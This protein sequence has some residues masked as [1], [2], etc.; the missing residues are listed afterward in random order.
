MKCYVVYSTFPDRSVARRIARELVE[1]QLVACVNLI[2][3]VES[4]YSWDSRICQENEVL[5]MFKTTEGQLKSLE[6]YLIAHHPYDVPEFIAVEIKA[7][8]DS[9]L[10]WLRHSVQE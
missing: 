8:S 9:Y 4:I 1:K 5:S 2:P 7:G 6:D 10:S 3:A